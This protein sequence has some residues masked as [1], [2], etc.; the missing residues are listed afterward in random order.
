MG[1]ISGAKGDKMNDEKNTNPLHGITL[2]KM[3]EELEAE[4]GFEELGNL[5]NV[6]CFNMNPSIKSCLTFFRKTDWARAKLQKLYLEFL[7]NES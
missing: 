3:L 2:A 5:I 7:E 4:Y 1:W 6:K